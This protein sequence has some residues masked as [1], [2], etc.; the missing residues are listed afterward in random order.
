MKCLDMFVC[1]SLGEVGGLKDVW[2]RLR[3]E[4]NKETNILISM[5]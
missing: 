1:M 3:R 2:T 5:F 4:L